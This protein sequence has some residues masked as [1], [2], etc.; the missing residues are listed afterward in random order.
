MAS[1][2]TKDAFVIIVWVQ[3]DVSV[4]GWAVMHDRAAMHAAPN[5]DQRRVNKF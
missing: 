4:A 5:A 3:L 1:W 2:F